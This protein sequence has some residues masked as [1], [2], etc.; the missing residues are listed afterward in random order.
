MA[1]N[2][3]LTLLCACCL[4]TI[5]CTRRIVD[6]TV[7]SSKNVPISDNGIQMKKADSRVKGVDGKWIVLGFGGFPDM[8]EAID[9]AIEQYPG[10]VA[11]SDGVVRQKSWNVILF[12]KN[13]YIVEGTPVYTTNLSQ[14]FYPRRFN[15][16]NEQNG[17]YDASAKEQEPIKAPDQ[18]ADKNV[19]RLEHIVKSGETLQYIANL[20]GISVKDII[21]LNN[22]TSN[23]LY[24]GEKLLIEI[25]KN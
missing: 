15:D 1:K 4:L 24:R 9:D 21:I 3:I 19:L 18:T 20:Y 22:L 11:L 2:I 25:P 10:A 16:N 23:E 12:G 17:Y 6:F 14:D 13:K 7:I 5:S 8:K